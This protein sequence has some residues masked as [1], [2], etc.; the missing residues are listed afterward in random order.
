VYKADNVEQLATSVGIDA[1][2]L[3]ATISR[4]NTLCNSGKDDDFGKPAEK[5]MALATPPYYSVRMDYAWFT[6]AGGIRIDRK[7]QA[8]SKTGNPIPGLYAVGMDS[9]ELFREIY[10]VYGAGSANGHN[11]NSARVAARNAVALL[12]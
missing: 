12:K 4:Y 9:C 7:M 5:M 8:M 1:K 2:L 11:I 6:T 3:A 10:K